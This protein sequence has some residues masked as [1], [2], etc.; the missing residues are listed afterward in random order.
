M[1]V[2]QFR[3]FGASPP[4]SECD[5][6]IKCPKADPPCQIRGWVHPIEVA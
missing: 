2:C 4:L 1:R 3:H 5:G 6:K